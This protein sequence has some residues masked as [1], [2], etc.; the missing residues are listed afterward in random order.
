[1]SNASFCANNHFILTPYY[2]SERIIKQAN[3][4]AGNHFVGVHDR[5]AYGL[6]G[7]AAI[8]TDS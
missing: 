5:K 2:T 7:R 1:M 8:L 3:M 6:M 4:Q